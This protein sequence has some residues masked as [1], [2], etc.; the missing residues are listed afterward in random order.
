MDPQGLVFAVATHS[1]RI[2]LYDMKNYQSGPFAAFDVEDQGRR[3]SKWTQLR[4]SPD[5]RDL[6][7][8][9]G[10]DGCLHLLNSF[11]GTLQGTMKHEGIGLGEACFSPDGRYVL[12][13]GDDRS[14][15]V[16]ARPVE[17][18]EAR[19]L[20]NAFEGHSGKPRLV[21]FNP[22]KLMFASACSN[23]V[24]TRKLTLFYLY[25]GFLDP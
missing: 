11:D 21:R 18:K 16:W 2:Q 19:L 14:V 8:N 25:L 20:P 4:F 5:G 10:R 12:A 13:G 15:H 9:A 17:G 7:L 22:K 6:L 24:R 23:L 1:K 3:D